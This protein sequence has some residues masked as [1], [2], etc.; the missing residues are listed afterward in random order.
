VPKSARTSKRP[1][2]APAPPAPE[3]V[4]DRR[5]WIVAALAF[6]AALVIAAI[7]WR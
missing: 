5:F 2:A 4:A 6:A 7:A 1:A 3:A